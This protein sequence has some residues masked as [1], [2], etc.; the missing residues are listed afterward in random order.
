[1]D[2][3]SSLTGHLLIAMPT[4]MDPNFQRTVTYICEHNEGG[5]LGLV[6][7]RPLNLD[8][9]H[10]FE[11]LSLPSADPGVARLPVLRGGPVELQRGF[12]LHD[13]PGDFESTLAVNNQIR[14]TTS[15]DVLTSMASGSG[16]DRAIIVLGYSGW[17]PG[18]L[19]YEIS[20]NSWLSVP[21]SPHIIFDTPFDQRWQEAAGLLGVDLATMSP[22][23][24]HA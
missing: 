11:Q 5:A 4:L 20:C 6:I 9:G 3:S 18:Q 23:V 17:S 1:M 12:V 13:A 8:V 14:V 24:G 19:E 10:I 16:P 2:E 15:Q 22:E 7:N 21:A